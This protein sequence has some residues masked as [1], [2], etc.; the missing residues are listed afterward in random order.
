[1][2]FDSPFNSI[3]FEIN[4]LFERPSWKWM[5]LRSHWSSY[6][7]YFILQRY[8]GFT[9][10][11]RMQIIFTSERGLRQ[12]EGGHNF[13]TVDKIIR[14]IR[15]G[16][17]WG[18]SKM[19]LTY[20][21]QKCFYYQFIVWLLTIV[22]R[23]MILNTPATD[24][25]P[26]ELRICKKPCDNEQMIVRQAQLASWKELLTYARSGG[27]PPRKLSI[28]KAAI[29]HFQRFQAWIFWKLLF[30]TFLG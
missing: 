6:A 16:A 13:S 11:L 26:G 15:Q 19:F 30:I 25:S 9:C 12:F 23:P 28:S 5:S 3:N 4:S 17:K 24:N 7:M 8:S 14:K 29:V 18:P 20:C 21:W 1:M 27:M 10:P 2:F 22:V